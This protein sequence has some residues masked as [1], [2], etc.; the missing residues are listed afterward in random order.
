MIYSPLR[1]SDFLQEVVQRTNRCHVNR[2]ACKR[3][4]WGPRVFYSMLQK[5]VLK[6]V[7]AGTAALIFPRQLPITSY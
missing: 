1:K 3:R 6:Q 2:S 7:V 5:W 4:D